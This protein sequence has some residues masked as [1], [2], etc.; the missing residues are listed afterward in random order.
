MAKLNKLSVAYIS[1]VGKPANKR[2]IVYKSADAKFT[3]TKIIKITKS[4]AEGLV[5]GTVYEPG[6]KDTDGDWAD[7][8]TIKEAAHAFL[9]KGALG[10]VDTNHDEKPNGAHVVESYLDEKGAW[11]VGVQMDPKSDEFIRVQKGELTGLSMGAYC[12]KS[13][14]EPPTNGAEENNNGEVMKVIGELRD[15]VK[16]MA[17]ELA[18]VKEG[19]AKVPKS[20][21][22]NLDGGNVTITEKS[23][24]EGLFSEFNFNALE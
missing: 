2:D 12:V 15:E 5:Y 19:V 6:V 9:R 18:N 7:E 11:Q 24:G 23:E 13:D 4:D 3:D 22:L 10:N 16:K 21:Q 14:E 8:K 20:R 17:T 1:L